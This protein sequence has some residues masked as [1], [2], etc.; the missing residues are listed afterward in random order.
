[1]RVLI[2][3][4]WAGLPARRALYSKLGVT[5]GWSVRLLTTTVWKDEYGKRIAASAAPQPGSDLVAVPVA[6][7]GNI[8]LHF[9]VGRLRRQITAFDPDLVYIYHEPYAAATF[10]MLQAARAVTKAPVGVRSAQNLVKRYPVPFRQTESYVYRHSDFAVVVSQNVAQVLRTKGYDKPIDVIPMPVDLSI[11]TP[12]AHR[13]ADPG[14]ALRVGF[15]G[16][17]VPEKGLDTAIRA[18]AL[19]GPEETRLEVIGSGPDHARLRRLAADV[20]VADRITWRGALEATQ[21]ARRYQEMDVIVV[22]SRPTHRW[23]E[24]FGRVVIEAAAAAV[25]AIVS[26]SGELPFLVSQIGAGWIAGDTDS[27]NFADILCRLHSER[28]ELCDAGM[29]ARAGVQRSFSDDAIVDA[30]AASFRRAAG[31]R[32]EGP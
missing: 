26:A 31:P 1:M 11:F 16:R 21:V 27:R 22:P 14:R 17:L 19:T 24:Q 4:P 13:E 6:L 32:G 10:Q 25:P 12:G 23:S 29:T 18:I 3:H 2:M 5:T 8:P 20:G 30:L 15:V 9:F 7:S 28:K